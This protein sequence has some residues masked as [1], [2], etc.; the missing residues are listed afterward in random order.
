M[1]QARYN[2]QQAEN[3]VADAQSA[4][5]AS[6]LAAAAAPSASQA[7][8]LQNATIALENVRMQYEATIAPPDDVEVQS[9][10]LAID[11]AQNNYRTTL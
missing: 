1:R 4:Y 6:L 2:L 8:A 3:T 7:T 10:Q 11:Q 9:A 5:D